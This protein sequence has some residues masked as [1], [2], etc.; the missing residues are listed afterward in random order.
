MADL[1]RTGD[2]QARVIDYSI[3]E[4]KTG[5]T[6][7][8]MKFVV[9]SQWN[10]E[11]QQWDDWTQY[12]EH[13]VRG[14]CWVVKAD[15]TL[16]DA[17]AKRLAE[18]CGP[19]DFGLIDSKEWKP[20]DCSITVEAEEYNNKT[21]FKAAWINPYDRKPGMTGNVDSGKARDLSS[22]FGHQL[23]ALFGNTQRNTAVPS[24]R[25]KPPPA[26]KFPP[27]SKI[28][29]VVAT[30]GAVESPEGPTGDEIPF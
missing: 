13:E 22:R 21:T 6:G 12:G 28:E 19:W 7:I 29:P 15:G 5:S 23:R 8:N 1:D 27:A 18:A 30:N 9:L 25:P 26:G 4:A 16:N 11:T 20:T 17:N 10:P 2:F 24:S 14:T 3:Y